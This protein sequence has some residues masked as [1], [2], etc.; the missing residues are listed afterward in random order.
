MP[1]NA[2]ADDSLGPGETGDDIWSIVYYDTLLGRIDPE[3]GR[4]TGNDKL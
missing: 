1:S 2:Q 4:I 3:A